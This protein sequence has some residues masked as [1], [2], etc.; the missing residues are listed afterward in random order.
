M[1]PLTNVDLTDSTNTHDAHGASFSD[2]SALVEAVEKD[3]GGY[4]PSSPGPIPPFTAS[5]PSHSPLVSGDSLV[6]EGE[7]EQLLDSLKAWDFTRAVSCLSILSTGTL[8]PKLPFCNNR[9]ETLINF[10]IGTFALNIAH[11]AVFHIQSDNPPPH[12]FGSVPQLIHPSPFPDRARD[13]I[14]SSASHSLALSQP[15]HHDQIEYLT[16]GDMSS[17]PSSPNRRTGP[18][19]SRPHGLSA[20]S[21]LQA[22]SPLTG[23]KDIRSSRSEKDLNSLPQSEPESQGTSLGGHSRTNSI[24][25]SFTRRKSIYENAARWG[26]GDGDWS[27]VED[28]NPVSVFS[29]LTI[30][31][32]PQDLGGLKRR[33]IS[34]HPVQ[35]L[36]C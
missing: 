34:L 21:P 4:A 17:G 12:P 2:S 1:P 20:L 30:V 3:D 15:Q 36:L 16:K 26:K 6:E 10:P 14:A 5:D 23:P 8:A 31:R 9:S 13:I 24:T 29:T 27:E 28:I 11:I 22:F 19:P 25:K 32:A 18:S 33:V 7:A 35:Y